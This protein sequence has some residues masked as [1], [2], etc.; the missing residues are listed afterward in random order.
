MEISGAPPNEVEIAIDADRLTAHNLSIN[1]LSDRLRTLNFSISAGQIDDNGQRVRIQPVGEIT[2]L[3]EL[4]DTVID[5][6]ACARATSPMSGSRP[7][8]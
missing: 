7:R 4:R 2:D 6:R 5:T 1:E 8:A 3:Q